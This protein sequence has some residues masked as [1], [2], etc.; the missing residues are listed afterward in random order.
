MASATEE[1]ARWAAGLLS[2]KTCP[3]APALAKLQSS[4]DAST[5][6]IKAHVL[7]EGNGDNA[8]HV[9][10][11][12]RRWEDTFASLTADSA[13]GR[14]P[15]YQAAARRWSFRPGLTLSSADPNGEAPCD[16]HFWLM[17]DRGR[18]GGQHVT[19]DCKR[20]H[21]ETAVNR[22]NH[23]TGPQLSALRAKMSAGGIISRPS[24]R[25]CQALTS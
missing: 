2:G 3:L 22:Y 25:N 8:A 5:S 12:L 1:H 15:V 9:P 13:Y 10:D 16:R 17:A 20:N 6:E 24:F 23:L 21:D 14:D 18:I 19:G 7:T 11:L 4:V